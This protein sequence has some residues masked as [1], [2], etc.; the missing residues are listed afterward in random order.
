MTRALIIPAAGVGSR[1][2]SSLPKVLFPINGRPMLDYLFALYGADVQR[3]VLVTRPVD[4][5]LVRE[6]CE[7]TAP[8]PCEFAVQETPTGM[9]DAILLAREVLAA[10]PPDR[11]WI[12]WCDQIAMR[13]ETIVTLRDRER[14]SE[15]NNSQPALVMPTAARREPYIHLA[16]DASGRITRVLHRREGDAMPDEGETDSGL[17]SL[18][19]QA[20]FE[21]LPAFAA[22]PMA[23]GAETRERNFLPFIPWLH[24]GAEVVT[25][26][27]V[28]WI[29][30]VGV[31]TP[32]DVALVAPHLPA[33]PPSSPLHARASVD[34]HSGL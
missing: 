26:P 30:S 9:L 6:A 18:S 34:R 1:L 12:T 16:R 5:A 13:K 3:I 14:E 17:F 27:C 23:H 19:R 31:N 11:V 32:E 22:A 2:K 4:L 33:L 28:S 25:F 29:E 7:A 21:R 8:V 20:F 15:R 10:D 24:A